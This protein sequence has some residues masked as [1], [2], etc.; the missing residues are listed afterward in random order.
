[1]ARMIYQLIMQVRKSAATAR[2][3]AISD[4]SIPRGEMGP[5]VVMAFSSAAIM[6][7]T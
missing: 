4:L 3:C 2:G 6:A 7:M 5:N 1:M